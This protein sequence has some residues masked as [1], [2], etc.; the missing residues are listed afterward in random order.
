MQ[1]LQQTVRV[2][3]LAG[4]PYD[5]TI[6]AIPGLSAINSYPV[7]RRSMKKDNIE[8]KDQEFRDKLK[9]LRINM[10]IRQEMADLKKNEP[11][12]YFKVVIP[13]MAIL[14]LAVFFVGKTIRS[15]YPASATIPYK[16]KIAENEQESAAPD[17]TES[18][19]TSAELKNPGEFQST[20]IVIADSEENAPNPEGLVF[21]S[22]GEKGES[23]SETHM[24]TDSER[25]S[26]VPLKIE[27][28]NDTIADEDASR[29]DMDS[30]TSLDTEIPGT[31]EVKSVPAQSSSVGLL[32][33]YGTRIAQKFVCSGVKDRNC[34]APQTV[35]ALKKNQNPHVWMEVYSDSVPYTLKHVYYH[36]GRKY[37]EV[38]LRI[39]YRRMRTWSYITLTGSTL[40]GSWHVETVAEDG[41]VLGRADFQVL[42]GR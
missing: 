17:Q 21:E 29:D 26:E 37:V 10:A 18:E 11:R 6:L 27:T 35:F 19:G 32:S 36:E 31:D 22:E 42:T 4:F 40:V 28:T 25:K 24:A 39:E 7:V 5:G 41:T 16:V 8:T 9:E 34:L 14:V 20:D 23:S 3:A 1:V 30:T 13:L 38:P 12:N 2:E 33:H 15:H